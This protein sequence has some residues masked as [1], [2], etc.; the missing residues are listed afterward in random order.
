V[1]IL[2]KSIIKWP[3]SLFPSII[4]AITAQ[5]HHG[6]ACPQVADGGMASNME[7]GVNILNHQ[8]QTADKGWS[9]TLGVG[10]DANNS[11]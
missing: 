7:V 8:S 10:R 6:M 11:P 1:I 4:L 3:L 2:S 9:S 5:L